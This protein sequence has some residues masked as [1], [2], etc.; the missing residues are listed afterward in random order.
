MHFT[1]NINHMRYLDSNI[2]CEIS[3]TSF[4]PEILRFSRGTI[5][6]INMVTRINLLLIG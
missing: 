2:P 5:D 1:F 3:Y 4:S 6:L